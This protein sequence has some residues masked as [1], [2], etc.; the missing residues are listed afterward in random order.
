MVK[1]RIAEMYSLISASRVLV[2]K[3]ADKLDKNLDVTLD[4]ALAKY[5]ASESLVKVAN[6]ALEIFGAYGYSEEYKVA[7]LFRDS[8][9]YQ[10]GEGTSNIMRLI[11]AKN[12][13]G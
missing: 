6:T 10:I 9:M 8:K 2:Y 12:L 1:E 7:R 4:A 3:L 5:F 13:L 11:I